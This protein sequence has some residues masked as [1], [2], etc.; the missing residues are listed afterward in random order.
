MVAKPNPEAILAIALDALSADSDW[1]KVLDEL[2]A[3]IYVTDTAG[4]VTYWNQACIELAGRVP[5]LGHDRWCVTW[6]IYTTTG[7][8]IPH[9]ECPMARAIRQQRTIRDAVAIALRPDGTR[10]AFRPYPTPLFDVDGELTG[11]VNMLIDVTDQQAQ[12]LADQAERCR[13]LAD[14]MYD[15]NTTKVLSSMAE[16]FERTAQDLGNKR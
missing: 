8:F 1:R 6:K 12:A 4:S 11:A 14:A 10:I 16:E 15:R 9:D 5:Q 2:P 3:P 13:R 7:E